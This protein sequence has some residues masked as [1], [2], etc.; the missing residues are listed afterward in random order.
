MSPKRFD[1]NRILATSDNAATVV[2]LE[3][4]LKFI[5]RPCLCSSIYFQPWKLRRFQGNEF[6]KGRLRYYFKSEMD[7]ASSSYD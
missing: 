6:E 1:L 4:Q 3:V 5:P 2:I 7:G